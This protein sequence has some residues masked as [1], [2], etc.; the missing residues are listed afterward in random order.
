MSS[1]AQTAERTGLQV[2]DLSAQYRGRSG[3]WTPAISEVSLNVPPGQMTAVVGESGSGK[4]TTAAAIIGLLAANGRR[5]DGQ[6]TL[7]GDDLTALSGRAL[8]RVRGTRIG[9]VPQDPSASLNPLA[10]IGDSVAETLLI[11]RLATQSQAHERAL[12]LLDRVGIDDPQ[13]RIDEYPHELSGGMRQRALIAAAIAAQP[14]LI[15]A[16]EPTSALDVT[17]QKRIL[18][19]LDDLRAGG[20]GILFITHD[21]AVAGERADQVVVMAD[22]HIVESGPAADVLT[23][24][25]EDYTKRL[26]ANAPSLAAPA[27]DSA[28]EAR[29]SSGASGEP[30]LVEVSGLTQVYARSASGRVSGIEDV[31]FS[32]PRGTTH[33]IV[34]ESGSGKSTIAGIL[35]GF[36]TPQSGSALVDGID[37]V[38][39]PRGRRREFRRSVQLVHQNPYSA[40]DPLYPVGSSIAEP[41]RNFRIGA[42]TDRRQRVAE[43]MERV[44]L[45]PELA[46]RRPR[47][48]SGGQ[49]QRVAIARA[50]A[51]DPELVV[52]DE[53][54]SALDVTV[55]AQILELL[56]AL[57]DELGLTYVFISHDLAVVR[58]IAQTVSVISA[59][60]QV[61]Q[62]RTADIFANPQQEY[63]QG[64]ISA[65]PRPIAR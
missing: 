61:E 60:H 57:Q 6:V 21:L 62:G 46:D 65:I 15:V 44:A 37:A 30:P 54:V 64:L 27:V 7:D 59:G 33:G 3:V 8:S 35:S 52:F 47:E 19:L 22:G 31:S 48:L 32:V 1:S 11:H 55:Q 10:T 20:A 18:D 34:G 49:L 17:V 63:T 9:Y 23:A 14:E 13:R 26:I 12:E 53:A 25:R 28:A 36:I 29:P 43:L 41:L 16:D 56:A 39:L 24:P 38:D 2:R 45:P 4:T 58:Q 5:T 42:K 51:A 50:F 40:L